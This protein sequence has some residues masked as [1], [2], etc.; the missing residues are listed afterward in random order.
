MLA[1]LR[2]EKN[3]IRQLFREEIMRESVIYQDILQ[4]GLQQGKQEGELAVV[5][6]QLTRRIGS[7]DTEVQ[8]RLR[9]LSTFQLEDLAEALL[10]FSDATDL[11]NWLRDRSV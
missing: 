4:K 10:D 3:L 5:L 8:E 2:F 1:G 11:A 9:G 6:R 7:V